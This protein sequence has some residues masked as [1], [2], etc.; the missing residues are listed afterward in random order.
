[1]TTA[2]MNPVLRDFWS[3][4]SAGKILFGGRMSSKS[5][6]A[7]ANAVRI[8]QFT[9]VRILCTRMYQNRIEDSVY[10]LIKKQAYLF[11][12]AHKFEFQKSKIICK[13]TGSEF[14]F[15]GLARNTDEIKSIEGID[16]LWIEEAHSLTEAMWLI[17]EPTIIRNKGSECWVVFNPKLATDFVYQRFIINTPKRYIV[18]QINYDENPFLDPE[19]ITK[20]HEMRDEDYDTYAHIYLGQPLTDDDRAVIKRAW[21]ESATDAH[22]KL[23]IETTGA[24]RLGFDVADDGDDLN[25]MVASYGI[26]TTHVEKWKGLEDE[27]LQS[28]TRVWNYALEHGCSIDYDSIGVGAMAGAK[29]KELNEIRKEKI[30]YRKFNAGGAVLDPKREYMPKILNKDHFSNIKAQAWWNVADRLRKTHAWIT[31]DQPCDPNEIIS[32]SG[33]LPYLEALK[34]EL[35]TPHR[36]FDA[37]GKVKVESKP[38][39]AKRDIKSPNMADAFIMAHMPTKFENKVSYG[40]AV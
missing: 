32:L 34:M 19:S 24:R 8:A 5:W 12:V 15:Y 23:G 10:N 11:G 35:S 25:A 26:L 13:S 9:K 18:R 4:P 38:D 2:T 29:F 7:A 30:E 37:S 20:I 22:I 28:A 14:L 16:I 3:K 33:D 40:W 39:L 31:K 1:M 17:L 36:H 21:L 27:L 6:D